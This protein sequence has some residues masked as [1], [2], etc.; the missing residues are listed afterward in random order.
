LQ[1][2]QYH[3][4][5]VE[6]DGSACIPNVTN[7]VTKKLA[8]FMAAVSISASL[9]KVSVSI[10][11]SLTEYQPIKSFWFFLPFS[12]CYKLNKLSILSTEFFYWIRCI[13]IWS[14]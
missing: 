5:P 4:T 3:D 14:A 11:H 10:L 6:E 2:A 12:A 7:V 13:N 1:C 8:S 9:A